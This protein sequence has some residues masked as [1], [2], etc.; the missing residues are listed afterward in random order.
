MAPPSPGNGGGICGM[1]RFA[2]IVMLILAASG[3]VMMLNT[4]HFYASLDDEQESV[5]PN[6]M[7][8]PRV[9]TA[10]QASCKPSKP[11][12]KV[13][14]VTG[15]AGFIG[16]SSAKAL[17]A[18]GDGVLGL[19]NFNAYY[20]RTLKRAR[21][22][23]L[24]GA[25]VY[26]LE[27]DL[28]DAAAVRKAR[29]V[30]RF[31]HVL[32]LAAQAGVR[33]AT[34]DPFSY[35]ASNVNGM[36]TLLEVFKEVKPLPR[37]VYASSS[38]VYGLNTK[39][40]FSEED[41]VDHPASLYA[42]TK[43]SDEMLAVTYNH[44][45][46][47]SMTGLRF[48]TV[49]GP[50]GRPDMAAFAFANKIV[51]GEPVRIFQGPGGSE[52]ERDFTYIDDIVQGCVAAVDHIGPSEKPAPLRVYN[53]GNKQP[54]NVSYLVDL[55]EEF[56]GKKANRNYM[57]LP[58]TGDV[59]KTHADVSRARQELG[60]EPKTSLR[61]GVRKFVEWY[62]DFYPGGRLGAEMSEYKPL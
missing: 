48:F 62:K 14:L 47:F 33:Y 61:E 19:D 29:D 4:S 49:Y 24:Q 39:V 37:F 6:P 5:K 56:M 13:V 12:G 21:A 34:K 57:P 50:W 10:V 60:Y 51:K 40:P 45:Y 22:S 53:L 17:R 20:P 54:F 42:A 44:I 31:T 11:G 28:N 46:H 27:A 59:L 43:K 52:L 23:S 26:T 36:V 55:L 1:P 9:L 3:W 7:D 35:V 15:T 58:A 25:G 30:C 41:V 18:R 32:H 38:S 16:Y 8:S 2:F